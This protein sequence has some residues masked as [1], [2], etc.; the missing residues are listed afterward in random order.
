MQ[1]PPADQKPLGEIIGVCVFKKIQPVAQPQRVGRHRGGAGAAVMRAAR[2][3]AYHPTGHGFKIIK[4]Q[5]PGAALAQDLSQKKAVFGHGGSG[6][7]QR[8]QLFQKDRV[9]RLP[10][11]L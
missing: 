1:V 7:A 9:V 11:V 10:R 2:H 6:I 8:G 4:G 5:Q 3:V